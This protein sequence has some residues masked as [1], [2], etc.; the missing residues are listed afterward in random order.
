MSTPRNNTNTTYTSPNKFI[1][2]LDVSPHN[3]VGDAGKV[4]VVNSLEDGLIP[5]T[6]GSI[7][8]PSIGTGTAGDIPV[9]SSSAPPIFTDSS[10][11]IDGS[12]NMTNVGSLQTQG[13]IFLGPITGGDSGNILDLN[14][15]NPHNQTL[16]YDSTEQVVILAANTNGT[17]PA[18]LGIVNGPDGSTGS[19]NIYIINNNANGSIISSGPAIELQAS[20]A[21]VVAETTDNHSLIMQNTGVTLVVGDNLPL[22]IVTLGNPG[23][24]G[25]VLTNLTGGAGW[26]APSG[27]GSLPTYTSQSVNPT[28]FGSSSDAQYGFASAYAT[29]LSFYF[30]ATL[31]WPCLNSN[32]TFTPT[33]P[34]NFG[35]V[36]FTLVTGNY[37]ICWGLLGNLGTG[38]VQFTVT[39]ATSGGSPTVLT[40]DTYINNTNNPQLNCVSQF[41]VSGTGYQDIL[42]NVSCNAKNG[43]S[44]GYVILPCTDLIISP[45]Y[46]T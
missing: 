34:A 35:T 11:N 13:N 29:A 14:F 7:I 36:P 25:D 17:D 28:M 39:N 32:G 8:P 46:T 10:V 26:Q 33:I 21:V 31:P 20:V 1:E 43:A 9:W 44:S 6:I 18:D 22:A 23:S 15:M 42:L 4:Y 19:N 30:P 2:L 3:Y 27:G 38:I 40:F 45:V 37:A 12:Q 16:A 41:T 5:V 24:V